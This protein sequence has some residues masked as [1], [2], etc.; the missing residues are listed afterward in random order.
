MIALPRRTTFPSFSLIRT[1]AA[2]IIFPGVA[3]PHP[4]QTTVVLTLI[5]SIDIDLISLL[6]ILGLCTLYNLSGNRLYR[7]HKLPDITSVTQ[8]LLQTNRSSCLIFL[9]DENI[10]TIFTPDCK[11]HVYSSFFPYSHRDSHRGGGLGKIYDI[12]HYIT[13]TPQQI[14]SV[15]RPLLACSLL[16]GLSLA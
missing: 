5:R 8:G 10:L 15:F 9:V 7:R 1:S 6:V 11:Q 16:F 4:S 14:F 13:R 3:W 12:I 2:S